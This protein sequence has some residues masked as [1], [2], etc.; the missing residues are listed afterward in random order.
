M[1][2]RRLRDR[3][4]RNPPLYSDEPVRAVW[5]AT[6]SNSVGY[7]V[8]AAHGTTTAPAAIV[9]PIRNAGIARDGWDRGASLSRA[10]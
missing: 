4:P 5:A 3:C 8:I 7:E 9:A 1:S 6:G 2:P 10:R